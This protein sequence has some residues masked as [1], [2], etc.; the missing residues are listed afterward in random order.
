MHP[1]VPATVKP[2][3]TTSPDNQTTGTQQ[4]DNSAGT[5]K[6][7]ANEQHE[8]LPSVLIVNQNGS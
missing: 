3:V 7:P 8:E 1:E 6:Q 4:N 2:V 5:T